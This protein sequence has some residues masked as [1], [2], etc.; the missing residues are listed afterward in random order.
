MMNNYFDQPQGGQNQRTTTGRETIKTS[1]R[2]V[3]EFSVQKAKSHPDMVPPLDIL[4][5]L[6]Y[7]RRSLVAG[8][9]FVVLGFVLIAFVGIIYVSHSKVIDMPIVYVVAFMAGIVSGIVSLLNFFHERKLKDSTE[10]RGVKRL[11]HELYFDTL[12]GVKTVYGIYWIILIAMITSTILK[13]PPLMQQ[14]GRIM[15]E[16]EKMIQLFTKSQVTLPADE[17]LLSWLVVSL[18]FTVGDYCY[19]RFITREVRR[20]D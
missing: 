6:V 3:I 13:Y 14:F 19:V 7:I 20:A 10:K 18:L 15:Q 1:W 12:K 5:R 4:D 17:I 9:A 8:K 11:V 2:P 16:I